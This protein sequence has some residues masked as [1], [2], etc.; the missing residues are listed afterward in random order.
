MNAAVAALRLTRPWVEPDDEI[1]DPDN[2]FDFP[3]SYEIKDLGIY[4]QNIIDSIAV[5]RR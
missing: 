3:E 2:E 5:S 4:I 1:P